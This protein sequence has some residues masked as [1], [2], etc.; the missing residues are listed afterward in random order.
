[1]SEQQ[2][3]PSL[4]RLI[5]VSAFTAI[6]MSVTLYL[7]FSIS[8]FSWFLTLVMGIA[9]LS[10]TLFLFMRVSSLKKEGISFDKPKSSSQAFKQSYELMG[11]FKNIFK[12][13]LLITGFVIILVITQIV[14]QHE[15]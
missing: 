15:I 13:S 2:N 9:W 12:V 1:M 4:K 7:Y 8:G 10:M 6:I 5:E 14:L 3:L 11:G